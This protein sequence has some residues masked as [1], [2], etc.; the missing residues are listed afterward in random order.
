LFRSI[1]GRIMPSRKN[2]A[3]KMALKTNAMPPRSQGTIL[4][5]ALRRGWGAMASDSTIKRKS[6]Y[7]ANLSLSVLGAVS[8]AAAQTAIIRNSEHAR[9]IRFLRLSHESPQEACQQKVQ[10]NRL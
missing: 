3:M 10:G 7:R 4:R 5:A 2:E 9:A 6:A 8:F 1:R